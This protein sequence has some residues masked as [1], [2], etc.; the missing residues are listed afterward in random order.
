[1]PDHT[2]LDVP[3]FNPSEY[4]KYYVN[5]AVKSDTTMRRQEVRVGCQTQ[6]A[7]LMVRMLD[8]RSR[9]VIDNGLRTVIPTALT[10]GLLGYPFVL[11][12]M[13]G[14]NEYEDVTIDSDLYIRWLQV[15]IFLPAI[16]FSIP[17]WRFNDPSITEQTKNLL[18]LRQSYRRTFEQL[19]DEAVRHG[20]PIVRPL[21]W[22]VASTNTSSPAFWVDD[23]FLLG[24]DILVAPVVEP[25]TL[26]RDIYLPPGQWK[27]VLAD[28]LVA[29]GRWLLNYPADLN[30][31][32]FFE[33]Q[34]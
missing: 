27:D 8:R 11:P 20:W 18:N 31:L 25:G 1:M 3:F 2:D 24:N 7:P 13:I 16:Q 15:N 4:I 33:R 9:W 32:P 34:V 21:W 5:T 26:K 10:F 23:Q 14:G 17:P 19:T 28:N 22:I 6:S 12:D 30:T 29:G